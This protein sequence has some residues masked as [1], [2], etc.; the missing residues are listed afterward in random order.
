MLPGWPLALWLQTAPASPAQEKAQASVLLVRGKLGF[1]HGRTGSGVVI[2]RH[3]V[4]TNFHVV[5]GAKNLTVSQGVSTWPVTKVQRDPSRDICLLTVPELTVPPAELAAGPA[6]LGQNVVTVGYPG[7]HGPVVNQGRLRGI[8]YYGEGRL[9]QS[10]AI[11]LPGNS[12]G[13][14]FDEEGRLLGLTTL[15]FASSPRLNFSVPVAWLREL[16]LEP[17]GETAHGTESGFENHGIDLIER[18]SEDPRNWPTLEASARQWVQDRPLDE[19]G[20][21][22]LGLALSRS[23]LIAAET[24]PESFNRLLSE[25]VEAH[26]RSLSLN[27][28]AKTFNNLGVALDLLNRSDEAEQAFTEAIRME[29]EYAKAWL[30]LASA[31]FNARHYAAAAEAFRSGLALRP[32]EA[33]AWIRLAHCQGLL[34]QKAA[35]VATLKIGLRYRPLVVEH[36]LDLGVWLVDLARLDEAREVHARLVA[37]DPEVAARLQA[38]LNRAQAGPPSPAAKPARRSKTMVKPAGSARKNGGNP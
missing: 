10:D 22:A 5:E 34:N 15:T 32:D 30:N 16:A 18:L 14:L 27:K 1:D 36:W 7:G 21:L 24:N 28:N 4:A 29:P 23:A 2:A 33:E 37:M 11:T 25:G 20:W 6:E 35:A 38:Y 26:R 8:W 3:L 9:L 12:G 31:R 19:N 17:A 13:G